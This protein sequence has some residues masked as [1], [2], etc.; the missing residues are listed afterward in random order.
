MD[1]RRKHQRCRAAVAAEIELDGELYE[2]ET[3]DLSPG[4]ASVLLQAPLTKNMQLQLTLFLTE[5]GI[6]TPDEEPLCLQA[7]VMWVSEGQRGNT[8]AGLRFAPP[9]EEDT[10]RLLRLLAA[11]TPA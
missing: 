1:N 11:L 2:G 5:D 6:E 7:Q 9:A 8:L 3:R 4:G 10:K